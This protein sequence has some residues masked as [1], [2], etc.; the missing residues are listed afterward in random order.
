MKKGEKKLSLKK[1]ANVNTKGVHAFFIKS[2]NFNETKITLVKILLKKHEY[3][4][5][6]SLN[7]AYDRIITD[8]KKNDINTNT[9]FFIDGVSEKKCSANNCVSLMGNKSLTALSIVMTEV[10][11]NTKIKFLI[12]DS[13]TTLFLY[14]KADMIERFMY[15]FINKMKNLEMTRVLLLIDEKQSNELLPILT[16]SCDTCLRI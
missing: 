5:Y 8:L 2:E 16:Q 3:G 10:C 9:L 4:V 15:Y 12:F 13:V 14:N 1:I 6:V 11:K 7:N